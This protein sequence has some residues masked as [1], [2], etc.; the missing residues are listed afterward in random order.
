MAVLLDKV[1]NVFFDPFFLLFDLETLWQIT[2]LL[3]SYLLCH[4][5]LEEWPRIA[6]EQLIEEGGVLPHALPL[7][8][9]VNWLFS[10]FVHL[11]L[12]RVF[13]YNQN[14]VKLVFKY[15]IMKLK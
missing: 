3:E 9:L 13:V 7:E 5:A 14:K 15:S 1:L 8:N 2:I 4:G 10:F 11:K 12:C 6:V